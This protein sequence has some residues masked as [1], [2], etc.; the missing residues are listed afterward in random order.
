MA[1]LVPLKIK[2][3]L[4]EN[5]HAKYPA[6]NSIPS[7]LRAGMDW[8]HYIDKQGTSWHYD[9][10]CGHDDHDDDSPCGMQWGVFAVP[11]AFA[12]AALG[13]FGPTGTVEPGLVTEITEAEF[14]TFYNERAHAHEDSEQ[15]DVPILQAIKA[16]QDL[17]LALTPEQTK[18]LDPA[19]PQPG[20]RTNA[21]KTF[22]GFKAKSGIRLVKSDAIAKEV[23]AE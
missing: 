1:D 10:K 21:A 7:E 3:G 16:K 4:K 11:A 13:M 5:G 8:A 9:K 20:L 17:G 14:A 12:Q 22:A 2:I 23:I 6:F 15:I 19:D 18:A